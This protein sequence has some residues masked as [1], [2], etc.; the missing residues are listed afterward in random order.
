MSSILKALQKLESETLDK[1]AGQSG[2]HSFN[3]MKKSPGKQG[4]VRGNDLLALLCVG[5][6]ISGS[7]TFIFLKIKPASIT[8]V[9]KSQ[10]VQGTGSL[11]INN[12]SART[13]LL[14]GKAIGAV[15]TDK[16]PVKS[17]GPSENA[18][19]HEDDV[20]LKETALDGVNKGG[21]SESTSAGGPVVFTDTKKIVNAYPEKPLGQETWMV[22]DVST[23]KRKKAEPLPGPLETSETS[24]QHRAM[25]IP[26]TALKANREER[27]L[28]TRPKAVNE[29]PNSISAKRIHNPGIKLHAIS[30]TPDV[31]TRIAVINGSIVREGDTISNYR[32]HK[33]NNDDI[34]LSENGELWRLAFRDK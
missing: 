1:G 24:I 21:A 7:A 14:A 5:L 29:P 13:D 33:I 23:V 16:N 10:P 31:K 26:K 11:A 17:S 27:V 12:D 28:D 9:S 6:I 32:V 19:I 15:E 22:K 4:R 8:S 18:I 3:A 25:E 2:L 30:W 34:V 20:P